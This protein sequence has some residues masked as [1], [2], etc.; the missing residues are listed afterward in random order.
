MS[1]MLKPSLSSRRSFKLID[2]TIS[3]AIEHLAILSKLIHCIATCIA[4][5]AS[6]RTSNAAVP[7]PSPLPHSGSPL[8]AQVHFLSFEFLMSFILIHFDVP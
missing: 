7:T 1:S 8:G 5:G 3:F 2:L 4:N 6:A